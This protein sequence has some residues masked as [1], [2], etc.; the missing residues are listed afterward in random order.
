MA[1][2]NEAAALALSL[3]DATEGVRHGNRA[4][5]VSGKVF[6]WDRPFGK[7]DRKRFGAEPPPAGPILAVRA[8]DLSDKEA[9]LAAGTSGVFTIPHFD[10]Y[11]AVLVALDIVGRTDLRALVTDGWLACA[12]AELAAAFVATGEPPA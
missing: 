12:S 1:T 10:G 8:A 6:A 4:W 3:P 9:V 11:A 2:L 7:A 5:S